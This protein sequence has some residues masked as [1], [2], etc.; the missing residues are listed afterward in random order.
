MKRA[1]TS[2]PGLLDASQEEISHQ[3][4]INSRLFKAL[5]ERGDSLDDS[6]DVRHWGFFQ[7]KKKRSDF[8]DRLVASGFVVVCEYT[9]THKSFGKY[10]YA[11]CFDRKEPMRQAHLTRVCANL[12]ATSEFLGGEYDG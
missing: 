2:A 9:E 10:K 1:D 3:A 6:R 12:A 5:R 11:I 7:S 4:Q 8:Q